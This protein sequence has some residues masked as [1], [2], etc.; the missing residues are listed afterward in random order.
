MRVTGGLYRG[1]NILCPPG[2][3]R[4]S[5]DR[6]RESLFSILGDL[7]GVPFLDLFAG[8]GVIGIEAASRGAEPV[9]LVEKDPRKKATILKN[10]S[11]VESPIELRLM[12][13]ERFLRTS[14]QAFEVVFL[15]PPF[16]FRDKEAVLD[17]VARGPHLAPEGLVLIHLH[18]AET[19]S[20][21]RPGLELA[22]RREYGQSLLLFF[23]RRPGENP[24]EEG[25][26][27]A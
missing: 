15:D 6:M 9:V 14:E 11:F 26:A 25:R 19:L 24:A 12:P 21:D 23:R 5:M 16:D 1:R 2:I 27:P 8:T 7:S 22:D 18:S 20:T 17:S 4:P 10:I 3:I 13:A